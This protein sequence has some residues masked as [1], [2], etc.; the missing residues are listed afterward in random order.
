[1]YRRGNKSKWSQGISNDLRTIFGGFLDLNEW[2]Q[3]YLNRFKQYPYY[4]FIAR[5]AKY[6][7]KE[8]GVVEIYFDRPIPLKDLPL[9]Y[10]AV[11]YFF[12]GKFEDYDADTVLAL[13]LLTTYERDGFSL[14]DGVF[15]FE[16][17]IYKVFFVSK[18]VE[19]PDWY[20]EIKFPKLNSVRVD[21]SFILEQIFRGYNVP[22]KLSVI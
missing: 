14:V 5:Y 22:L 2:V 1:M 19:N 21:L 9:E 16:G 20:K 17:L 8:G 10:M 13:K 11:K 18:K 4:A 7:I 6:R 12:N 15:S 3:D